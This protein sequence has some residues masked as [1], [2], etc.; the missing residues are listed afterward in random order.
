MFWQGV[1]FSWCLP[2]EVPSHQGAYLCRGHCWEQ[3]DPRSHSASARQSE[4]PQD[5]H[6]QLAQWLDLRF[7]RKTAVCAEVG[8]T[9]VIG[10]EDG[11]RLLVAIIVASFSAAGCIILHQIRIQVPIF[12]HVN[13]DIHK[14]W[15]YTHRILIASPPHNDELK[16][17]HA[18]IKNKA[19]IF[20]SQHFSHPIAAFPYCKRQKAG[21]GPGNEASYTSYCTHCKSI[22]SEKSNIRSL[23]KCCKLVLDQKSMHT[24]SP[25]QIQIFPQCLPI[26]QRSQVL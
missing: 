20:K 18:T 17:M 21:R 26:Q 10:D 22:H 25:F 14:L 13:K 19:M 6:F 24:L 4:G 3:S 2:L 11:G 9:L 12:S 16:F 8:K 5:S 15:L 23:S 7:P 1:A